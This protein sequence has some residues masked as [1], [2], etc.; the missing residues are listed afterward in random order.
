MVSCF[1]VCRVIEGFFYPARRKGLVIR[2][3][4]CA[5]C[6]HGSLRRAAVL[7]AYAAR[8]RGPGAA[9]PRPPTTP[10]PR[11][12]SQRGDA[13]SHG[14][15]SRGSLRPE[16]AARQFP[17]ADGVLTR[18]PAV[19]GNCAARREASAVGGKAA[20]RMKTATIGGPSP[21]GVKL[22]CPQGTI[23]PVRAT[24]P[25]P[26]KT[27]RRNSPAAPWPAPFRKGQERG[28]QEVPP[29]GEAMSAD[30]NRTREAP[31]SRRSGR[32]GSVG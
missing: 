6:G 17:A 1:Y 15:C 23:N 5:P 14:S 27:A 21:G 22:L 12:T 11:C 7:A 18:S 25:S 9:A 3:M 19:N 20:L 13:A 4:F 29:A 10:C 24:S 31:A 30:G 28:L 2:M 16:I 26:Q 32:D 8:G